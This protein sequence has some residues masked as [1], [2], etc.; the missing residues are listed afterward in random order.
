MFKCHVDK[1]I[2]LKLLSKSEVEELFVLIDKNRDY[3]QLWLPWVVNINKPD[4]LNSFIKN[5]REKYASYNGFESGIWF[6]EQLVG[7]VGLKDIDWADQK[8]EIGYW[9]A[10]DWQGKG[11][12]T[13]S[14]RAL[15]ETAFI[16]LK[17]NKVEIHCAE[18][19]LKSK[20]V[21]ERLGFKKEGLLRQAEKINGEFVNHQIYGMLCSEFKEMN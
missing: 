16:K 7:I 2:Y 13:R 6:K 3:L 10:S 11:I 12:I 18:G 9:L 17:L 15:L 5:A 14:C 8:A 4:D 20:A 19:N 1:D 21:A